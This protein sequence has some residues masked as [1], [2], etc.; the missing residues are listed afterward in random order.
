MEIP[1]PKTEEKDIYS[2]GFTP[3]LNRALP[4]TSSGVVYDAVNERINTSQII[5]GGDLTLKTLSIG[6][7]V[8]QVAPGDDIQAAIDAVNREGGGTVQLLAGTYLL[9]NEIQIKSNV[10]LVGA[11]RDIT[12]LNF[13]GQAFSVRSV[14]TSASVL[15]SM[16][17][18]GLT[19]SRSGATAGIDVD[20]SDLFKISN[21]RVTGGSAIG[22]RTRRCQNYVVED[23]RSDSNLVGFSLPSAS[24]RNHELF[25]FQRCLA[26]SNTTIG[27]SVNNSDT[28]GLIQRFSFIFCESRSNT[29]DGYDFDGVVSSDFDVELIGCVSDSNG[30]HGYDF[31]SSWDSTTCSSCLANANLGDGFES[32]GDTMVFNGCTSQQNTGVDW[33]I[34]GVSILNGCSQTQ[35]NAAKPSTRVTLDRTKFIPISNHFFSSPHTEQRLYLMQNTSGATVPAG[36]VVVLKTASGDAEEVSTTTT[37]GDNKVFGMVIAEAA[38]NSYITRTLLEGYTQALIV[39]NGTSSIAIGDW[40]STYS[41]AYYAKKAVAGDTVFAIALS[42]PTTSTAAISALLVSPRLI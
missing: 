42:A 18:A 2:Y 39:S 4:I 34:S 28:D 36:A 22:I 1:L 17:I 16:Y 6:G 14:G 37:N 23:A 27:F 20:Y 38:N 9:N 29:G 11:G 13:R 21:V 19:I 30:G 7:L 31:G 26:D 25:S 15:K 41:H 40:L 12:V 8:K 3:D 35:T 5:P 24:G 10:A 33:D 32:A